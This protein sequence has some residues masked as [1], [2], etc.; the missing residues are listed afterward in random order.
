MGPTRF[1][2]P[3]RIQQLSFNN[4]TAGCNEFWNKKWRFG[5]R[6]HGNCIT[7]RWFCRIHLHFGPKFSCGFHLQVMDCRRR[8]GL[9]IRGTSK[10]ED[11]GDFR[12]NYIFCTGDLLGGFIHKFK[13]IPNHFW[14]SLMLR[15]D[16]ESYVDSK[17]LKDVW[18]SRVVEHI[19]GRVLK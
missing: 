17:R 13:K 19:L 8:M 15:V 4:Q 2:P 1:Q 11:A 14:G 5:G 3:T 16:L 6:F 18:M 9:Q 10:P 7:P 12:I